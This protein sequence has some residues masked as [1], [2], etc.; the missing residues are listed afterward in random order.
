[1]AA[2]A[3][4]CADSLGWG[5]IFMLESLPVSLL[6][7]TALGFLAGIG[8][9]GGSL[10]MLWLTLVLGIAHNIARTINLL[11]FIPSAVIA[12]F[13]RCRQG[14]LNIKKILPAI[15]CGC[16][17]AGIFAFL[18]KVLDIEL[19]KKLFGGL[20]LLTGVRELFYRPRKAK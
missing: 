10:L 2:Q 9:G 5:A 4:G 1:M 19:L 3:V 13:F 8:V 20:L 14:T 7:G 17:A 11:F 15:I 12:T 6:A 16:I 18:S